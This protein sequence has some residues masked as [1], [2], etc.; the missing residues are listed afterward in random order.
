[1]ALTKTTDLGMITISNDLITSLLFEAEN[2]PEVSGKL[3]ISNGKGRVM[4]VMAQLSGREK[5]TLFQTRITRDDRIV[6]SFS[7]VTQFGA[8]IKEVTKAAADHIAARLTEFTDQ[9]VDSITVYIVGV[10]SRHTAR[11]NV[12]AVYTY[13]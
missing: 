13:D 6:L 2:L 9:K 3:W 8:S 7:V 4:G 10:R 11:R 5:N 12:K 1:M